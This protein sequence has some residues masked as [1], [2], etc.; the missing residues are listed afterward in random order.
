MIAPQSQ[1]SKTLI[2]Y[3]NREK[4]RDRN[5]R[6]INQK[7]YFDIDS[8][9][10]VKKFLEH[11][12]F[13]ALDTREIMNV[14]KGIP[15]LIEKIP[16][17]EKIQI[18]SL[19]RI[20]GTNDLVDI[21]FLTKAVLFSKTVGRV[22]INNASDKILGYGT[23]FMISPSL[24]I[25]NHHV[26]PDR[27]TATLA[28]IEMNYQF[29]INQIL[30]PS[31][32]FSLD[33]GTFYYTDENLDYSIV[34]VAPRSNNNKA[35]S[36]FGFNSLIKE[37]GK[38][39]ISQWLNI[40]EHPNG[41]PKQIG[42]RENQL[43]DVLDDFLQYKTDTAPGAS[44]SPVYNERWEVV[45]LHHS[46]VYEKD[47]SGNIIATTGGIWNSTMGEDKI[48]WTMNEGVR[49]SSILK[50]M[51]ARKMND[52]ET[53]LYN[54]LFTSKSTPVMANNN[55]MSTKPNESV[56]NSDGSITMNVPLSVT[57]RLGNSI[58]PA[59][60]QPAS[61]ISIQQ[62][63]TNLNDNNSETS[64]LQKAKQE[65]LTR[66]DVLNVRMGYVF[67]NGWITKK[68]A[69][70]VTVPKRK[71][72]SQL[73]KEG[74][75][76]LPKTFLGY[77]VEVSGP[78]I[79]ELIGFT[80]GIDKQEALFNPVAP[81][82][83]ESRYFPPA[84]GELKKITARMK[85]NANV[86]PEQG[87]MNLRKYLEGTQKTLTVGMYDFGATH[88]QKAIEKVSEKNAFK[89]MT[90]AIQV[91]SSAGEG[92]KKDD[93]SDK[94]M[95]DQLG[96]QLGNKFNNA[97][98]RIGKTNGWVPSSYHIKVA[99]RDSKSVSVSSGNWQSS[100]QPDLDLLENPTQAFLLRTYNREWHIILENEIIAKA[101]E[102]YILNDYE[103]NKN[104]TLSGTD[105]LFAEEL[106]F[107][108]PS[109]EM[110]MTLEAA[111][112]VK[113]FAP[114]EEDREFTFT[115]LLSPD[116]YFEE[117]LALIKSAKAELYIQNQT[118]NAPGAD[119]E[120]LQE[121]IDVVLQKQTQGVDVKIIFRNF[122]ASTA[123]ENIEA[124]VEMGFDANNIKVHNKCHTKGI[125]VDGEKVMIG[126]QN[127]SNDGV[128][129]NRDA[130]LLFKDK[131]LA[132]YFRTIFLH[133]W[134][135][136]AKP[137]IGRESLTI[138][139]VSLN[140]SVPAGMMRVGWSDIQ[141]LL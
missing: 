45:G 70:V 72:I 101:Y 129:V 81:S 25:T 24:M 17:P 122:I 104:T 120:K 132:E 111:Q 46:G 73:N 83:L 90:M 124:L 6:L 79:K 121:L 34:A 21:S 65:F 89:N 64:V 67:E 87:W 49:I 9:L 84:D 137:N 109:E 28:K 113:P 62:P 94:D 22:W 40:I 96:Q 20:L 117:V 60:T 102:K 52:N 141:E 100:N 48:K 108:I 68:R 139:S 29:D 123:R 11:R 77:P 131:K 15:E 38:T 19:E 23:G 93:L 130:S 8:P 43:I 82:V 37:E 136:L 85:V 134:F 99:V 5:I 92:S 71:T 3:E 86:S 33:P 57:F 76:A 127:W 30:Q 56:I 7:R 13:G 51:E 125:I 98:I 69:V 39:I 135:N 41:M 16:E 4:E 78:T 88:I 75:S 61:G 10:R 31:E 114:F 128:S 53:S 126:S 58:S 50:H 110:G 106:Y 32:I 103:N 133:D 36:D 112:Q 1:I 115:P 59:I 44:G 27:N 47:A 14:E 118:F 63:Q 42:L 55:E 97:W 116:N 18:K 74:S 2:R 91:G 107:L 105:E 54:Q 66:G 119:H 138:E 26:L 95:V 80:M 140:E 35:L 12:D